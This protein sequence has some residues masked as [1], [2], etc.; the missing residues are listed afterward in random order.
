MKTIDDIKMVQF[1]QIPVEGDSMWVLDDLK[2]IPHPVKRLFFISPE[3][4][5]TRGDH[6]HLDCWQT[7]MCIK[8]KILITVDD[9]INK[10]IVDLS[11]YGQALT[12]PPELWC[13][14]E[15]SPN[16]SLVVLCSH[17][18]DEKDYI[19]DYQVFKNFRTQK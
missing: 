15:Y 10:Q 5:S 16:S 9:G 8:G 12:I 13:R 11:S 14:Q 19:R 6:A 18:Y 7:L 1:Q 3:G 17:P 4:N 2:L